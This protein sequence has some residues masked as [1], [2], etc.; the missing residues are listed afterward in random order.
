MEGKESIHSDMY[1]I[2]LSNG[3]L[4]KLENKGIL[5]NEEYDVTMTALAL[6]LVLPK[7]VGET[8][9]NHLADEALKN[10]RDNDGEYPKN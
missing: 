6:H 4:D 9:Y 10:I 7:A 8:M 5:T 1:L 2:K 3:I